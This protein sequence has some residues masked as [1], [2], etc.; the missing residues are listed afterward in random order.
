MKLLTSIHRR[1]S[2]ALLLKGAD[3]NLDE[4]WSVTLRNASEGVM[5]DVRLCLI[6]VP[7]LFSGLRPAP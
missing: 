7:P 3:A 4:I 5:E 2:I 1:I 6:G